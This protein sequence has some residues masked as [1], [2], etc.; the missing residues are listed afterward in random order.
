MIDS[1]IHLHLYDSG[2]LDSYIEKWKKA[3]VRKVVAVSN[4]LVSSYQ[5]LELQSKYPDFVLASIGFHPELALPLKQDFLE[6]KSLLRLER[7]RITAIGEIGLPHYNLDKL[8]ETLDQHIEVLKHYLYEAD[9]HQLPVAL[10][11][12]HDKAHIVLSLLQHYKI[13]NAH[14]HWLKAPKQVVNQIVNAGYYISLTPEVCYR[15]RD[16]LL[17]CNV[18]LAQLLMETDGP[19]KYEGIFQ[20]QQTEPPFLLEITRVLANLKNTTED[21]IKRQTTLN[22]KQC[23]SSYGVIE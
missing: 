9:V 13:K 2:T 1:H 6:W 7:K 16:Q 15:G 5:T 17:A 23:Y 18:P 20:N 4:D 11:A 10:H 14:F 12:V 8:P 21:E 19:W 22:V 3:G